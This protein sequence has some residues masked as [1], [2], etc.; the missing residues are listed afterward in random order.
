M[1]FVSEPDCKFDRAPAITW[2]LFWET[3]LSFSFAHCAP[4]PLIFIGWLMSPAS[5]PHSLIGQGGAKKILPVPHTITLLMICKNFSTGIAWMSFVSA[6]IWSLRLS[7]EVNKLH[8]E[9]RGHNAKLVVFKVR[10]SNIKHLVFCLTILICY[11]YVWYGHAT[12]PF[13]LLLNYLVHFY[14]SRIFMKNALSANPKFDFLRF[15]CYLFSGTAFFWEVPSGNQR[16][17]SDVVIVLL[18]Q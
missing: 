18:K 12:H 15:L 14:Y 17:P 5:R 8:T 13:N 3:S 16:P 7:E 9:Q 10:W 11:L 2:V 6:P 1:C 4:H